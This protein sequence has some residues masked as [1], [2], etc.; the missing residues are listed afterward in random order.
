LIAVDKDAT[1][2]VHGGVSSA[3]HFCAEIAMPREKNSK[4]A[5]A[6]P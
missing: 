1:G 5:K 4:L 2:A 6:R 3:P